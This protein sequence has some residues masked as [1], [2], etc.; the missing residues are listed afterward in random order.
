MGEFVY[1]LF[2]ELE[3]TEDD[4][5][6][7]EKTCDSEPSD[8][9]QPLKPEDSEPAE[10]VEACASDD[11]VSPFIPPDQLQ[12]SR[13]ETLQRRLALIESLIHEITSEQQDHFEAQKKLLEVLAILSAEHGKA[14]YLRYNVSGVRS[15]WTGVAHPLSHAPQMPVKIK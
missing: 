8:K 15:C 6:N 11:E 12:D 4:L 14:P 5:L 9:E 1:Y 7:E 13:L 2:P 10:A 3:G